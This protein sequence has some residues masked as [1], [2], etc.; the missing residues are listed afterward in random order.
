MD[1]AS[2]HQCSMIKSIRPELCIIIGSKG[3][4]TPRDQG[5]Y[6]TAVWIVL[7]IKDL[8]SAHFIIGCMMGFNYFSFNVIS[9]KGY[10]MV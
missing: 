5:P 4:I 2:F 8:V 3:P 7:L 6:L 9:G 10:F 1:R